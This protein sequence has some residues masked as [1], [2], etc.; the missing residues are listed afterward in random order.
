MCQ[1]VLFKRGVSMETVLPEKP[2][3]IGCDDG[4]IQ[5]VIINLV[6]NA[7]DAAPPGS[8]IQLTVSDDSDHVRICVADSGPGLPAGVSDRVFDPFFTTKPHGT[9]LGLTIAH[10]LVEAHGG[11]L[12]ACNR[13]A[14]GAEFIV[15]L[16]RVKPGT[17]RTASGSG[18]KRAPTGDHRQSSAA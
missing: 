6:A 8:A 16:P 17:D 5:R 7:A 11:S 15:T 13:S 18:S 9:G 3:E 10:R 2:V 12:T 14:G 4:A 1:P